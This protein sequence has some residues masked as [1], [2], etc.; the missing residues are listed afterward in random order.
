MASLHIYPAIWDRKEER[1]E[2]LQYIVSNFAD[3]KSF[4]AKCAEECCGVVV[5]IM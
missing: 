1:E 2:N 5:S 4:L 3:L